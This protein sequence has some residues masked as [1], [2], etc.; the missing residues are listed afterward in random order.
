MAVHERRY[1]LSRHDTNAICLCHSG[2]PRSKNR[3]GPL[4][5]KKAPNA[6]QDGTQDR[7]TH[8]APRHNSQAHCNSLACPV[9]CRTPGSAPSR[10]KSNHPL[11]R[12]T[13]LTV[14]SICDTGAD[15]QIHTV[16]TYTAPILSHAVMKNKCAHA[17]LEVKMLAR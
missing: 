2:P 10:V 1:G 12:T 8:A 3:F 7:G 4:L 17:G 6:A 14:D 15:K 9:P 13:A 16:S 11:H 5:R